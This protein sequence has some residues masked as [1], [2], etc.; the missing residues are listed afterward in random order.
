MVGK[1][2]ITP[3]LRTE[4]QGKPWKKYEHTVNVGC[5]SDFIS[6]SLNI[7]IEIHWKNPGIIEEYIQISA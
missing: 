7:S 6:I 1:I 2:L 4:F 5:Y 3:S